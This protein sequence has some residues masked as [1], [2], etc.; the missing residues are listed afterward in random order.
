MKLTES[1]FTNTIRESMEQQGGYLDAGAKTF[2]LAKKMAKDYAQ[3]QMNYYANIHNPVVT[4]DK[5]FK[6]WQKSL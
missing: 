1:D 6:Q 2:E 5:L 4:D 3:F